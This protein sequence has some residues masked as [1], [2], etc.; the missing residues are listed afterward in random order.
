M[1]SKWETQKEKILRGLEVSPKNK[2]E[3]LR[4]MNELADR[5]LSYRQKL[6]RRK[7]RA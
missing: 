6:I 5:V 2:L 4:L 3:A 1:I 7:L